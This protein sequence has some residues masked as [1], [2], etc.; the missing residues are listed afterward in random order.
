MHALAIEVDPAAYRALKVEAFRRRTPIPTVLGEILSV[1]VPVPGE[2]A[3][4]LG[5]PRWRRTGEGRR[6]KQHT[7]IDIDDAS[8]RS[9]HVEAL[10]ARHTVGRWIG[11]ILEA[12]AKDRSV[13]GAANLRSRSPSHPLRNVD[14]TGEI[15]SGREDPR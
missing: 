15:T 12:W 3:A 13:N 5:G 4:A 11:L 1:R 2:A 8:W 14:P 10:D 6:A 7:R 9:L